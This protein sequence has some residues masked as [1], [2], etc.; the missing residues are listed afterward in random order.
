MA[1]PFDITP[2]TSEDSESFTI[3]SG[4]SA[5]LTLYTA[6]G[7]GLLPGAVALVQREVDTGVWQTYDCL[8]HTRDGMIWDA[9]GTWRLLK[10]A[11]VNAYGAKGN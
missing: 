5:A 6:D 10:P 3:A 1:L 7:S 2:T 4:E 9:I 8:T 11:S